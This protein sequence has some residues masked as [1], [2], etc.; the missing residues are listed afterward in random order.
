MRITRELW[1]S[2]WVASVRPRPAVVTG[3]ALA[4]SVSLSKSRSC[5]VQNQ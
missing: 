2:T 5:W 4:S 3:L 1:I